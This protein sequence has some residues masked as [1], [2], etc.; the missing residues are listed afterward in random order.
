M[1][2]TGGVI[3]KEEYAKKYVGGDMR[4]TQV[5]V[6]EGRNRGCDV[7]SECCQRLCPTSGV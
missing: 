2:W 6:F 5:D 1:K 4:V 7:V 3:L